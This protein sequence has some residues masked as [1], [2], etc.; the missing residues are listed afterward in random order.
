MAAAFCPSLVHTLVYVFALC[1]F[2]CQSAVSGVL[3]LMLKHGYE[4]THITWD[5]FASS[6]CYSPSAESFLSQD[7]FSADVVRG[8]GSKHKFIADRVKIQDSCLAAM[9]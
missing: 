2:F 9:V 6:E 1:H 3:D 7:Q 4:N 5:E 8:C